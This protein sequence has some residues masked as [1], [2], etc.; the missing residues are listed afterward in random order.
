MYVCSVMRRTCVTKSGEAQYYGDPD[1][2]VNGG[3]SPTGQPGPLKVYV[4][5]YKCGTHTTQH[6]AVLIIFPLILQAASTDSLRLGSSSAFPL[7]RQQEFSVFFSPVQ[8][9][10]QS[11]M[12][13]SCS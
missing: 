5:A 4:Y 9:S 12:T 3:P 11:P 6:G 7:I 2:L 10:V 1:S 13:G 8:W